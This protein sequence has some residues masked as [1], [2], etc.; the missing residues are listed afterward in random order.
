MIIIPA[1]IQSSR[2]PRK[3]LADVLGTPMVVRVAKQASLIDDVIVATDCDEVI[4]VCAKYDIKAVITSDMH[5]SGTDRI[6]EVVQK[7]GLNSNECIINLQGDEPFIEKEVL[8]AIE[9]KTSSIKQDIFMTSC[10]TKI[11]KIEA[12]NPN[13][14]KVTMD[15]Y[16]KALY[17]SRSIIPYD[18]DDNFDDYSLH[19][20]IYGFNVQSLKM[21]CEI[22]NSNL[23]Q[24]EKLE[25]LRWLE[26][27]ND[28][29]MEEVK[30][31]SFGIDSIDDLEKAIKIFNE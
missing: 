4:K 21:F 5:K 16:Q 25:Q 3:V 18:R 31:K 20:G 10:F 6:Y 8:K 2:F 29:F 19:L 1:R 30:T 12:K 22:K 14:V 15:K 27:G 26:N 24:T 23:E 7:M 11:N 13:N 28:I 9:K 17:F